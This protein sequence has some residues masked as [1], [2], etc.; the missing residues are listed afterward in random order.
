MPRTTFNTLRKKRSSVRRKRTSVIT[1]AKYKPRTTAAN[2]SLIKS[3]AFAI[4]AVKRMMPP[5]IYTDYQY[6]SGYAP[7]YS[8]L[9]ASGNFFNILS[10]P[11]M[12]PIQWSDVL[13]QDSNVVLASSTLV[14]R[15]QINLRYTLGQANWCQIST[16]V[17]SVRKDAA[18]R[19]IDQNGLVL[20]EDYIFNTQNFNPRLNS[21]VLKVHYV[22]HVSLMASAWTRS[23]TEIG[24][25]DT[26]LYGDPKSTW[27]K[28]QVNM[29]LN[30][31]LRQPTGTAWRGMD[32]SQLPP[33]QRLYLLT[34]F[35]GNTQNSDDDPVRVDWDAMYTCFNSS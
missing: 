11:L 10:E 8:D 5:P 12:S 7:F 3:N 13:R 6:T 25:D 18:N 24:Q 22:R 23:A 32:D 20:N 2:R 14:K 19:D 21:S 35:K 17:V 16:F 29:T 15:M 1:R 31:R 4:R 33:S 9:P 34:F 26:V 27:A 30:Y 28:G